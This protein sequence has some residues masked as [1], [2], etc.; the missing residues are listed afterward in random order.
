LESLRIDDFE[1]VE[2]DIGIL[3]KN[4]SKAPQEFKSIN[5][6][7]ENL[8]FDL[9]D[10]SGLNRK[11]LLKKDFQLTLPNYEFL[12]KDSLNKVK[13]GLISLTNK[14][15]KL[16]DVEFIPRYGRYQYSRKVGLQT[17]VANIHIPLLII[18]GADLDNFLE[19]EIFE[20]K[21]IRISDVRADLFR[22][23]RF[24]RDQDVYKFMPQALMR[25]AG[26]QMSLDSL[27][28]DNAKIV[29]T[30]F[31]ENGMVPGKIS[32]DRMNVALYPFHLSKEGETFPVEEIFLLANA[33]LNSQ[34]DLNMQGHLFFEKPYPMKISAQMGEFDLDY[35]NTILQSNAFVRIRSGKIHG[36]DWSFTADNNEAIGRMVLLYSDLKL[37][38]LDERTLARGT[39]RKSI[40]T[41]V[42]NTFAVRSN[43]PRRYLRKPISST[44][45]QPRDTERFI[46]NYWWTATL[47]GLKGS[48]GLG[49]P[50]VPKKR[51]QEA[52]ERRREEE[53]Q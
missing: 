46:F 13:I 47:S 49:Q 8:Q 29:Y 53:E 50:K 12:L 23:K 39:G 40:L 7:L 34:A 10:L 41:F 38:L 9:K 26:I 5:F 20:A 11:E 19:N 48:L 4:S 16:T 30:E 2:G 45:Y 14:Q 15:I 36:A 1:I 25:K 21:T 32:F 31:P 43:N 42:L 35:L 3:D 51:K 33:K 18:E 28:I 27:F 17:D 24:P 37:D 6:G 22:D 52:E 44:I